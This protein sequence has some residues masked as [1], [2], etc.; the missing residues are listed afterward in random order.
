MSEFITVNS[1]TKFT[2]N[3]GN[4]DIE[5]P[6]GVKASF[7]DDG[8]GYTYTDHNGNNVRLD[9][10]DIADILICY[11]ILHRN[12]PYSEQIIEGKVIDTF[13]IG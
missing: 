10:G 6:T 8:N 12:S 4:I 1:K 13:N 2:V 5:Y 7:I 11:K 9:Y 3:N